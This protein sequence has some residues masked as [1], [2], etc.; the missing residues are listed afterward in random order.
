MR[1]RPTQPTGLPTPLRWQAAIP[2]AAYLKKIEAIQ[3]CIRDGEIFE[4]NFA[5][6]FTASLPPQFNSFEYYLYLTQQLKEDFGGYFAGAGYTILSYSPERFLKNTKGLLEARPIKGTIK[7]ETDSVKDRQAK[8][9]LL[10]SEKDKAENTM[11]VDLM[12]NDFSKIAEDESVRVTQLCGLETKAAVHH[13]VSVI[14]GKLK[15]DHTLWDALLALFPAGS[16]TGAPK[17]Q[18]MKVIDRF[19]VLA[20]QFYC[21]HLFYLSHANVFDSAILIRSLFITDNTMRCYGGGAITLLS[22]PESEWAEIE[23]KIAKLGCQL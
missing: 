2:K 1:T 15:K 23:A 22:D 17:R 5:N 21:G 20:R 4:V 7:R 8:E 9:T 6:A 12:R 11:I 19:E 18:S 16:I 10:N 3:E 13:L 14:Q